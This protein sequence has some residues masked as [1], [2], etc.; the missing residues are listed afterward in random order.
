MVDLSSDGGSWPLNVMLEKLPSSLVRGARRIKMDFL[1][2]H[3]ATITFV[4]Q[5]DAARL[6]V[7]AL[8]WRIL[9]ILLGTK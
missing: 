2:M 8:S 3:T 4:P 5:R 1:G 9:N 7:P 6:D